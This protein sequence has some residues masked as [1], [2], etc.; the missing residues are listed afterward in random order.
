M[1]FNRYGKSYQLVLQNAN[2]L[3]ELLT[4]DE[5]HWA[6]TSAPVSAFR[7]DAAFLQY[8]DADKNGRIMTTEVQ[9]AIRWLLD[10]LVDSSTIG[11]STDE[12]EL[13][14]IRADAPGGQ[15]LLTTANYV[16]EQANPNGKSVRLADV[17]AS[18][19]CLRS[20]PLNGDGILVPEAAE[21]DTLRA[22]VMA[23]IAATG[24]SP[25]ISGK[26]GVSSDQLHAFATAIRD[27]LEWK[28][29]G[30]PDN[31][32]TMPFGAETPALYAAFAKNAAEIDRFF[33]LA[34]FERFAPD[35]AAKFLAADASAADPD[36]ALA[37]APIAR[38]LPD[39]RLPLTGELVNPMSSD[40]L[41]SLR[42]GLFTRVLGKTP[43]AISKD[44]WTAVRNAL[45]PYAKYLAEKKGAIVESFAE[46]DLRAWKDSDFDAQSDALQTQDRIV[47]DR[48]AAF[49]D[50]ERLLLFHRRLP[51]FVNNFVSLP[52]FYDPKQVALFERGR[53][54]IDGRWFNFCMEVPD[55][56][57]HAKVAKA[58]GIFTIYAKITP[59]DGP[60]FTVISPATTGT[61]GNL[62]VGKRG[63]FFNLQGV[64]YDE[65]VVSI[66][67]N[68]ISLAEA[69]LAPFKNI[70]NMV[71]GKIESLSQQA[72]SSIEKSAELAT[73]DALSGKPV[74]KPAPAAPAQ[75]FGS[76]FMGISVS[77]AALSSGFAFFA[78]NFAAMSVRARFGTAIAAILIVLGPI[79][80]AG[81]VKLMRQNIGPLLEGAGWSINKPMGLTTS[82]R[83]Q[84]TQK[85][86][87][88]KD[89][90][91][92][93]VRRF[94]NFLL[95]L[96]NLILL[97]GI[98]RT[99]IRL[100]A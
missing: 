5:S 86:F 45:A 83:R 13:A 51:R 49:A 4:I 72:Q 76:L 31:A 82:L 3:K 23:A 94:C 78:K 58:A 41:S 75:N 67:E 90:E 73:N 79:L 2:D 62:E 29:R 1:K 30:L 37:A 56:A 50:L 77:V 38:I 25:D 43:D 21:T 6:A 97:A 42:N 57:A 92:T 8:L 59:P 12:I 81:I 7:E 34:G 11:S 48:V 63:V 16:N 54:L 32:Q 24:G 20:K 65:V 9:N 53:L 98:I 61:R 99:F 28:D 91:G 17:R 47:S 52:E 36:A 96:I 27:F 39:G 69:V 46:A 89:A 68:P 100:F 19:A 22:Y 55:A 80:L 14:N 10:L 66:I 95:L 44:E 64:E 84:L 26:Q 71:M 74:A 85:P 88:P 15:A 87:Y 93:P 60:A 18:M 33:F 40:M 70:A 35:Q